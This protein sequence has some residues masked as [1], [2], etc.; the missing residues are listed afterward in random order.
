MTQENGKLT[1]DEMN[2][3]RKATIALNSALASAA[4]R[5]VATQEMKDDFKI[6]QDKIL[7][8]LEKYQV[9]K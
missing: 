3:L 9:T 5:G 7:A 6:A 8:I 2:A 4:M 1:Q